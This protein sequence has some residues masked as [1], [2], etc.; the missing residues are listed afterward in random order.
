VVVISQK[1]LFII[2]YRQYKLISVYRVEKSIFTGT[3]TIL[4][5]FGRLVQYFHDFL[6]ENNMIIEWKIHFLE[7]LC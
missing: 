2:L 5:V 4:Q 6:L 7:S 1:V 3:K